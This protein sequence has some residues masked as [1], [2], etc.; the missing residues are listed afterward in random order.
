MKLSRFHALGYT[1]ESNT[2]DPEK[3]VTPL[4]FVGDDAALMEALRAG[5][6]G[7]AAVFYDQHLQSLL[8]LFSTHQTVDQFC[9]PRS[10]HRGWQKGVGPEI[11]SDTSGLL[12]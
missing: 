1:P 3:M 12:S 6:P 9:E 11:H 2:E 8:W 7:A 10:F 5:H 4:T